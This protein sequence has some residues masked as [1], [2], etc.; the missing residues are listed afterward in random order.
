MS[1]ERC[2]ARIICA[3]ITRPST[4]RGKRRTP[5]SPGCSA[6]CAAACCPS[7][8]A[9]G[10]S[11]DAE[12]ARGWSAPG[13]SDAQPA[14]ASE[15]RTARSMRVLFTDASVH[16][17]HAQ[18]S[19]RPSKTAIVRHAGQ[20]LSDTIAYHRAMDAPIARN[21]LCMGSLLSRHARYRPHHTA[22]V[23]PG[24]PEIRLDW[25]QLD[26]CVNRWANALARLGVTRGD[27]VATLLGNGLPLLATY[28]ACAKLGAAA[29][30]L[31]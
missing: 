11:Y 3:R 22:V 20:V 17:M 12:G 30:P 5:D 2:A 18:P 21:S 7:G 19:G 15:D 4:P 25:R 8:V 13:G 9:S 27:R 10:A 31:S 23:V 14:S 26:A 29:V 16:A 6:D 1:S 24:E 28:W